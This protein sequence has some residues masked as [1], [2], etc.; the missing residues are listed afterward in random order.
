MERMRLYIVYFSI[1]SIAATIFS[2]IALCIV[3]PRNWGDGTTVILG[4]D[5]M[6][7]IVGALSILIALLLG[8]QIFHS[9]DMKNRITKIEL[10][11]TSLQEQ[12]KLSKERNMRAEIKSRYHIS[13]MQGLSFCKRQPY[14]AYISFYD[15][16]K[17]ALSIDG[18]YVE[19]SLNDLRGVICILN[20]K[21]T[22]KINM[23]DKEKI[24]NLSPD[25]FK[26]SNPHEYIYKDYENIYYNIMNYINQTK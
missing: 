3:L 1:L 25:E 22:S 21:K 20:T 4:F 17:V 24:A 14:T 7:V 16:L 18:E 26:K 9:I 11:Q 12:L 10:L 15:A 2:I 6:G 8:W 23:S 5:Y 13:R 19:T